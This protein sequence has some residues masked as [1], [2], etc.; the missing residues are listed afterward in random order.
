L[1]ARGVIASWGLSCSPENRRGAKGSIFVLE[2]NLDTNVW[3]QID[4]ELIV[5]NSRNASKFKKS[6]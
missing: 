3:S 1:C 4:G 5:K 2:T 6:Q